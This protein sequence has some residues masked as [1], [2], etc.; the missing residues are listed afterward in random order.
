MASDEE[1]FR[2]AVRTL[3]RAGAYPDH[4]SIRRAMGVPAWQRRSGLK[5]AQTRWRIEE[6][7]RAGFDWEASKR[8]KALTPVPS[9]P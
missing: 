3:V 5:G 1:R 6:V 7:E 4:T 9:K 2:E 8:N